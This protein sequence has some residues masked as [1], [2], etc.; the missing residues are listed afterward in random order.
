MGNSNWVIDANKLLR[1]LEW[2]GTELDQNGMI[3]I[4]VCP[5]CF[6][7]SEDGH[8]EECALAELIGRD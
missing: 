4:M 2:A 5:S 6:R 3:Q 7:A 8:A 1:D